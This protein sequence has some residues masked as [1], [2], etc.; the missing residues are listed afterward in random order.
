MRE[1][2]IKELGE[3]F[4]PDNLVQ[5]MLDKLPNEVWD[6]GQTFLDPTCGNGNF[7]VAVLKRKIEHGIEP[8]KALTQIYGAEWME[9]NVL[10]CQVRLLKVLPD[11]TKQDMLTV[12][13][14]IVC[15]NHLKNGSLDY[16]FEFNHDITIEMMKGLAN[17]I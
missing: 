10:E 1:R 16:D 17:A 5:N 3:V 9:D 6:D 14:N 15:V 11:I 13:K 4:T 7:L 2:K 12:L 8:N